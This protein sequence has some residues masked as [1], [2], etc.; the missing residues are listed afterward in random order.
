MI[1]VPLWV[2]VVLVALALVLW[3]AEQ[4]GKA[5]RRRAKREAQARLATDLQAPAASKRL[6]YGYTQQDVPP[7]AKP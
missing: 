1:S 5:R 6:P 7:K 3:V 4:P 2:G